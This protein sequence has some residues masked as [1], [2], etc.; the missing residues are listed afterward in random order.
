M[1]ESYVAV[2]VH[3]NRQCRYMIAR[4]KLG[5]GLVTIA[6]FRNAPERQNVIDALNGIYAKHVLLDEALFSAKHMQAAE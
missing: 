5:G 3:L 1:A 2:D 4:N 6:E